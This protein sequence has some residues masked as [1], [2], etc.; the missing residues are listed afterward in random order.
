MIAGICV[1]RLGSTIKKIFMLLMIELIIIP[2]LFSTLCVSQQ[3]NIEE[4]STDPL[5]PKVTIALTEQ[6]KTAHVGPGET[7]VVTFS[8]VVTVSCN[9]IT[10]VVVSL[11]A[12]DTWGSAVVD[13][14]SILFSN[15]GEKPFGVSV[16]APP[17]TSC[18]TV[19]QVIVTGRWVMYPGALTGSADPQGGVSGRI[20]IAQFYDF[21]INSPKT[22]FKSHLGSDVEFVLNIKNTGNGPDSFAV[23][24]LNKDELSDR[25]FKIKLSQC[26]LEIPANENRTVKI[27]V[28]VPTSPNSKSDHHEIDVEV[29][30]IN[31]VREKTLPLRTHFVVSTSESAFSISSCLIITILEIMGVVI[32]VIVISM[33]L[34]YRWRARKGL[35][36]YYH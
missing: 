28:N 21:D 10:R 11:A 15:S 7:G 29:S 25:G 36:N 9:P 16:R 33:F 3:T 13:P 19:G 20:E 18:T 12:S 34:W 24:I 1:Y 4:P 8:G 31:G 35:R 2:L 22:Q 23:K 6:S 14:N 27:Y 32:I 17:K 30:S 5:I 26:A